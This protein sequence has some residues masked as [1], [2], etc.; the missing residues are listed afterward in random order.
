[1]QVLINVNNMEPA[2]DLFLIRSAILIHTTRYNINRA[3]SYKRCFYVFYQIP[4]QNSKFP[5][6]SINI[7]WTIK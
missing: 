3:L 4:L 1:M 6:S 5:L 7:V 2:N